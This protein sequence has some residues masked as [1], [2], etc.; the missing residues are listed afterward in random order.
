MMTA[1]GGRDYQPIITVKDLRFSY[2]GGAEALRGVNLNVSSG[3][4]LA[5]VGGNGSGKTTLAKHMNGLLKPSSGTVFVGGADTRR[6]SVAA[7]AR[8]VGYVFQN[9]DHQIFCT[10]VDEEIRFGPHNMGFEAETESALVDR[11]FKLMGVESIRAASP[12]SLSLGDRR[13]VTI[14]SVLATS[15]KVLVLDEPTTGLDSVE[16]SQL[17]RTLEDLH[18]EGLTIILITHEMKLVSQHVDRV[19][20]MS[21]GEVAADASPEVVFSDP[22]TL[23]RCRLIAPPITVLAQRLRSRGLIRSAASTPG[24]LVQLLDA[25]GGGTR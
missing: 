15:P 24:Q 17:M 16:T 11:S 19:V 18:S 1:N 10:S 20:V 9:P 14:A 22:E 25:R 4:Y 12:V 21:D 2:E 13:K 8:V 7:L 23:Q 6:T 3:E 5:V